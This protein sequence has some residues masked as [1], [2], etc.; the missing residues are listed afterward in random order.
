[1]CTTDDEAGKSSICATGGVAPLVAL[2]AAGPESEV[3]RR[4]DSQSSM[5]NY[6]AEWNLCEGCDGGAATH[7]DRVQLLDAC[8]EDVLRVICNL[9]DHN[10]VVAARIATIVL[11]VVCGRQRGARDERP[12]SRSIPRRRSG[13]EHCWRVHCFFFRG[14]SS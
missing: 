14:R 6:K 2:L 10:D 3:A 7:L 13:G 12:P 4:S 8:N 11:V 1:M 5:D 9:L